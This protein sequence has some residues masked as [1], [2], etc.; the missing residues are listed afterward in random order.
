VSNILILLVYRKLSKR[1]ILPPFSSWNWIPSVGRAGGILGGFKVS[2]FDIIDTVMGR[3]CIKVS[4]QDL[5]L[6]KRWNLV[7]VY[8]AAQEADKEN[9]L[10]ELVICAVIRGCLC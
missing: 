6:H 3:Y 9:F 2:R 10:V 5:K 4:L 8:G 1:T 7:L